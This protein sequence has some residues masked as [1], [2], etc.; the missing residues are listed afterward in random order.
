MSPWT[1]TRGYPHYFIFELI[2]HPNRLRG[3]NSQSGTH[4]SF[5][6]R[7]GDPR[8]TMSK[9][10]TQNWNFLSNWSS[11]NLNM[12]MTWLH[13]FI[14]ILSESWS[15]AWSLKTACQQPII[16]KNTLWKKLD[17]SSRCWKL[18]VMHLYFWRSNV[19][20]NNDL[21]GLHFFVMFTFQ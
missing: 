13:N 2:A 5:V 19:W 12:A 3:S 10:D 8:F 20:W 9:K 17:A 14:L 21:M 1:Q 16:M 7:R 6:I 11:P 18:Y 15:C 4:H